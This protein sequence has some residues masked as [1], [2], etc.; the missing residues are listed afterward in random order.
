MKLHVG[1]GK[2]Y[3]EGWTNLDISDRE[4]KFDIVDEAKLLTKIKNESCDIICASH[5]LEH[6]SRHEYE[7]VLKIWSSKLKKSGILRIAVPNFEAYQSSISEVLNHS[8]IKKY[9]E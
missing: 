4:N 9:Y 6:F 1:C 3:L 7:S 8:I 5:V 2:K